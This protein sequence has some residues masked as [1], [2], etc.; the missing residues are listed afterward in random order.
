MANSKESVELNKKTFIN[1]IYRI[2]ILLVGLSILAIGA[3]TLIVSSIGADS[4]LVFV[5]GISTTFTIKTGTT[6]F[7]VN[8]VLLLIVLLLNRKVIHIGTVIVTLS[9]GPLINF[10]CDLGMIPEPNSFTMSLI[11]TLI[12]CFVTALGIAIYMFANIGLAPFEAFIVSLQKRFKI[13]FAYMKI[14]CD[15]ILFVGGW[16]LGGI[17]G[18]GSVMAILIFGPAI[19]FFRLQLMKTPLNGIVTFQTKNAL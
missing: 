19:E 9:I 14:G 12:A 17:I 7:I 1:Y 4:F 3:T 10:I 5:D 8:G 16:L 6:I 2:A 15:V 11:M 18:V 13:R